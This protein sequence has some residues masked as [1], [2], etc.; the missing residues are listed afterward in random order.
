MLHSLLLLKVVYAKLTTYSGVGV[1]M[2]LKRIAVRNFRSIKNAVVEAGGQIAIVGGNGAGKSTLLRAVDRFYSQ[3]TAVEADDFFARQLT[4]PIEIEL[5]FVSFSDAERDMFASRIHDG[6]MTVVRVF[7]AGGGRNN[8]RYFGVMSQHGAFGAVRQAS[9]AAPARAAYN[10]LRAQGSIYSELPA[11]TRADQ[12]EPALAEWEQR[13]PDLC[14]M[15]RDDGQFFGF[16]NVA[17]GSLQKA[18][19]FVF[20]P[21]VRDV[22]ADAVDARGAVISRLLELVVRSTI[23][24]RADVREFQLR[25]SEE[26]RELTNPERLTELGGLSGGL[27]ET[28]QLFYKEAAVSLRWKPTDDF[29][30]PPPTADVLLDD[31]GFEGPVDRKGHGLQR[32]FVLTL[33]QHL[34]KATSADIERADAPPDQSVNSAGDD[35]SVAEITEFRIVEAD[36]PYVLP[37]LILAIEEPEL[38]QHPTKQ[39]H[40]AKVLS[41]LARGTLPGVATQTQILF[42]THSSL[43]VSM[44]RFDEIRLARRKKREGR[45]QKE[46]C[47]SSSTLKEVAERLEVARNKPAGT[48]SADGLKARLHIMGS[49]IAEGFFADL[50]VLVEGAGDKAALFAAAALEDV[51]F[52]ALGIALIAVDG[53]ANLDRPAAI[54]T[55]LGIPTYLLWDSDRKRETIE[56][57]DHNRALQRLVGILEENVVDAASR[58]EANY[59]C[60]ETN[61]ETVLRSEIGEADYAR[62]LHGVK[63]RYGIERAD[64][65]VKA[66]FAMRELLQDAATEGKKSDTLFRIVQA[67][68]KLRSD[69]EGGLHG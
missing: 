48:Y 46:C 20:I 62:F 66:P 2:I 53:K 35:Q 63:E 67:I 4:A 8:G 47:L 57:V 56:G 65:A 16:T 21:A 14:E 33:L 31:D 52:E 1:P 27:T 60:F 30:I 64:H 43:F 3:S 12:I 7:E 38:Y 26:Y 69:T 58:V 49:E 36:L 13:H 54:F 22:S 19:S 23:Q 5:T 18:T 40:F 25:V 37:G 42:A 17:R 55:S 11:V 6:E 15:G 51:D 61:L 34:A 59:A 44:D 50:V 45:D 32:A 68:V 10:E 24:R 41:E 9:G 39:R 29:V 28:L